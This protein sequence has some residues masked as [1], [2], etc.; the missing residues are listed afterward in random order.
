M[1]QTYGFDL[2]QERDVEEINSHVRL[3]RHRKT[4]AELLSVENNDENKCFA[5]SFATP[6]DASDGIAHILEH[7]V[8]AGSRKYPVKDPFAELLKG[9]MASFINAFTFPDKTMYPVASTNLADFYNL[10]DVYLDAVFYPLISPETLQQEGWHYELEG[11]EFSL[12]YKGVVFNE[13]KG[14]YSSPDSVLGRFSQQYLFPDTAYGFDS[15]GDP[16][17]IPTL[18]YKKFK[19]FHSTYYHPSNAR[20]YFWGDDDPGERLRL[21]D[22]YLRDF[23]AID[24][25]SSVALQTSFDEPRRVTMGYDAGDDADKKG[26]ISVDWLLPE[27]ADTELTTAFNILE[28]AILGKSGSPLRKALIDSGLGE[29]LAN[30]GFSNGLRQ[31]TFSVGMKGIDPAD[32]GKVEQ[33]ILD[34]LQQLADEGIDP[35]AIEAAVN[36]TEFAMRELNT[37]GFP[38]GLA[39]SIGA[40][41]RWL[42][43]RDPIDALAFSK[44][45]ATVK[46]RL[47]NGEKLLENL[48]R[49][50]ILSNPH[51]STLVLEPDATVKAQREADERGQLDAARE[52][53]T[54]DDL[55]QIKVSAA[56]LLELQNTP[57]SPE[58]LAKVPS[59]G[60]E[61]L[62]EQIR[63]V[64]QAEQTVAGVTTYTHDQPTN[65]IVYLD[66]GFNL[67]TVP[68]DLLSYVSLFSR[69]LVE[70]GTQK[71]SFV[72]LQQRIG[73]KT[74]GIGP[75]RLSAK[76]R[77]REE[78]IFW[79][80]LRG[81]ATV[82]NTGDL[83]DIMRDI[84]LTANF[85][86][87]D[88]FK[89]IV[90]R[91]K[92]GK[93]SGL[94]PGG[95]SVVMSRLNA[96]FHTEGWFDEMQGGV[97]FLFFL[98]DLLARI[99]TDWDSV[100]AALNG[101]RE[102]LLTKNG[103]IVNATVEADNWGQVEPALADFIDSLPVG[104]GA[105]Q[106]W[107]PTLLSGAEGLTLP[108]Q[109]N[110]VGQGANLFDLGY[111]LHG[112]AH[113]I[114][115]SLSRGYLWNRVRLQGGAYGAFARFSATTGLFKFAS[116]R[117]PNLMRT[118]EVYAEAAEHLRTLEMD[119]VE[120]T[121][122][123]VGMIG[124]MDAYK[125]PDAKGWGAF[126]R[127][128]TGYTDEKR[129]QIRDEVL[130]TT[131]Q[132]YRQFG[133]V[134]TE[135]NAAARTVV[136]GAP[137]AISE[138]NETLTDKMAI[139]RVL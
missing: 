17:V 28:T 122:A 50:H 139:T 81:K 48:I 6:P 4:G 95:H 59:L 66:V 63:T 49:E 1:A 35:A 90:M 18:T 108:A 113:V 85:D 72:E 27:G 11:D 82:E 84:V 32:A 102:H 9:S 94:I 88:R 23:E 134:L 46:A 55:E 83:L 36:S 65:G 33:L 78:S 110:Y 67:K 61:D 133:E 107:E 100:L 99:E 75:S 111:T 79:L 39:L 60:L 45:L 80:F 119:Q 68:Q 25:D 56:K 41:T 13:M 53:M 62:N 126:V 24:V 137:D 101:I 97:Q 124:D 71:Q 19:H 2:V 69:A 98:R 92:A 15:G 51:R 112:S 115:K 70:M 125:L 77:D 93:E 118:L 87:K 109:V 123:I 37:G 52:Q 135:F 127:H 105:L 29:D 43:G 10:V 129:Q 20:I 54:A 5:I 30:T 8:L 7:S 86:D 34:T 103:L 121:K 128:L 14:A 91:A 136:L 76:M 96:H 21:M 42:H 132:H 138:A 117:D 89:Q 12:T 22:E 114:V 131:V 64:A 73:S 58:N 31:M 38:R 116:Y 26:M 104:S 120:L 47:E 57:D 74:G 44:P 40:V 106:T 130:S 3:Y 16:A